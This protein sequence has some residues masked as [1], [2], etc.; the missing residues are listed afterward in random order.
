MCFTNHR[1][2]YKYLFQNTVMLKKEWVYREILY[3]LENNN[4]AFTQKKLAAVCNTSIGNV[5][6]ALQP[7]ERMNALDKK[8]FGFHILD[9]RKILLYWASIRRLD[10]DIVYQTFSDAPIRTIEQTM[11]PCLFTAYSAYKF[12]FNSTPSD[13]SEV[14]AYVVDKNLEKTKQRFSKTENPPNLIILHMDQHLQA[15]DTIPLGQLFVDLWNINTWYAQEFL[16]ELEDK[17]YGI[18]E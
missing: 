17:I 1:N 4:N 14:F 5:N 12:I 18:L 3:Q 8:H 16:K 10:K 13:Y 11:P 9:P 7:F 6:K 15:F 2:I